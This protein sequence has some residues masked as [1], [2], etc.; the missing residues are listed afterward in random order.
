MKLVIDGREIDFPESEGPASVLAACRGAGVDV[1]ALCFD[2]SDGTGGHCRSC[3]VELDERLVAA[4]T[5]QARDGAR[6]A[7]DSARL[8]DYRRDLAELIVSEATVDGRA[9][10]VLRALGMDRNGGDA[11][12]RYPRLPSRGRIDKTHPYLRIDLDAC[13]KCRLCVRSCAEVQGEFVFAIRGRGPTTTVSWGDQ[14][15][16]E[17]DCVACGACVAACPTGAIN[18]VDREREADYADSEIH[19]AGTEL[20]ATTPASAA[21]RTETATTCGYCGVGCGIVVRGDGRS[22]QAIDGAPG[23]PNHG[24]LCVKG[25]YAHGFVRHRDRLTSPLL[26]VGDRFVPIRWSDAL[27]RVAA[28]FER[29]RGH[30]AALS[31]ARCTNEENYLVQKWFR[32]GLGTNNVDCCARVCHSPSAAGLRRTLGTGAAT[33]SVADIDRSD[34]LFVAGA[35]PSVSHPIIG[36]RIKQAVLRGARLIVI[37]PRRT[38]L[39][40]L[41][42]VWLRPR[43]GTNVPLLSSL[44][45]A[46]VEDGAY[47]R[48][49]VAS[50]TAGFESF[51]DQVL[52]FPPETTANITNVPPDLVRRAARLYAAARAPMQLHGLGIT[53][54]FQGTEAVM[55]LAN[56]A[57]LCGAVGREGAGVNPLRGQN[58]VQGAADMGCQ[59][60]LLPGYVSILDPAA[61]ARFAERWGRDVPEAPG[62]TIPRMYDAMDR[63]EIRGMFILGEDVTLTDPDTAS[64]TSRLSRLD[65]LV[66]QEIFLTDTARLAHLVL[67][68]ASF[69]EKDGTFTSSERRIRRVRPAIEPPGQA[70]PDWRILLDLMA[71]TNYPQSFDSP[72]E[73]WDEVR[74]L[75]PEVAGADWESIGTMGLQWPVTADSPDG[76][77]VLH[78]N[79]FARGRASFESVEYV[80]SPSHATPEFP[81]LLVTGR[82]LEH[83][84]A[85]SM[86]RR[87]PN[88]HLARNDELT[89][90]PR[91]ASARS[92][93]NGDAVVLESRSGVA[94][95]TARIGDET[96]PGTVFLS[97]H[98]PESATNRLTSDVVD[99]MTDCPEYKLT[100]V[101]VYREDRRGIAET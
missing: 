46:L 96:A 71:T 29:L 48:K 83:Y 85:G 34:L 101:E 79:G 98:F 16:V 67:P 31:S 95:A 91:D 77:P 55:L 57:L 4:C 42:D 44:A 60:D 89:I 54:H 19:A 3:L 18:D 30:L 68:G 92:I 49:F 7:T 94:R 43:P 87:T 69:L 76:T 53:E 63:G 75:V 78:R 13:I 22:V 38:E 8:R 64:V 39:A 36:A 59:P 99:R 14:P 58:N 17:T 21:T 51:R 41:A 27:T 84:N 97:F 2:P 65:F 20:A 74:T 10:E 33:S 52:R 40:A 35:N 82:V 6:V 66:V 81:L 37:D 32:G 12:P 5:T 100:A 73:V 56:I 15:F 28:E 61:R 86:T 26:R 1:P 62:L 70:R 47:D 90:H 50:R 72:R 9:A 25:R 11:A 45:C 80:P 24:H 23:E 88:V 93:R